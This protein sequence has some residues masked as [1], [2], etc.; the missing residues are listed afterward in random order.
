MIRKAFV[1]HFR[2]DDEPYI[3]PPYQS[4]PRQVLLIKDHIFESGKTMDKKT[5][6]M[7]VRENLSDLIIFYHEVN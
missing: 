4:L 1:S 2:H 5:G 3:W 7:K 6:H